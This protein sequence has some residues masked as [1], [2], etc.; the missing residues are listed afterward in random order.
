MPR[1]IDQIY[2]Y[3]KPQY[4][5]SLSQSKYDLLLTNYSCKDPVFQIRSHS[6]VP[7]Y[8]EFGGDTLQ[9]SIGMWQKSTQPLTFS[10]SYWFLLMKKSSKFRLQCNWS[11]LYQP[12]MVSVYC[13]PS[14]KPLDRQHTG[15]IEVGTGGVWWWW[16]TVWGQ[17]KAWV[18]RLNL[19]ERIF[20]DKY[21][22][23][24][25]CHWS[26]I[27]NPLS[28]FCESKAAYGGHLPLPEGCYPHHGALSVVVGQDRNAGSRPQP[29][30]WREV[31][32]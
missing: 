17:L 29:K 7:K 6:K 1:V 23:G 25:R 26:P 24:S 13:D 27:H 9:P 15:A 21:N 19:Q 12:L 32:G 30:T 14:M 10:L 20:K 3:Y 4:H 2:I 28:H 11:N 16:G 22:N 18:G 8:H 5:R 31:E